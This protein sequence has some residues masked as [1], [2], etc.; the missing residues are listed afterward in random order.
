MARTTVTAVCCGEVW[1][2]DGVGLVGYSRKLAFFFMIILNK[3]VMC[4]S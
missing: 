2:P 4:S 3:A 1:R